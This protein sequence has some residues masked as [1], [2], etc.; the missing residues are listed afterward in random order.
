MKHIHHIIPRHM[1]G[2]DTPANLIELTIE[3]HAEAHRVLYEQ[4]GKV[5]DKIAY[6]GLLKLIGQEE[7]LLEK[8]R[9]GGK[10]NKG[11]P[12]TAEHRSKI[13]L[14]AAGGVDVHTDE[15][16]AIISSKMMQNKNSVNHKTDKYKQTQSEAMKLA[17]QRRKDIRV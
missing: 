12:K 5:E 10:G 8:S 1:G 13:S 9:L 11:I 17:W 16:K 3:E 2:D 6:L 14:N 7:M 15:T 4:Y